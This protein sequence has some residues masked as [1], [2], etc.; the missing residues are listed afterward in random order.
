MSSLA[1]GFQVATLITKFPRL[2]NYKVVLL[3]FDIHYV[4][5]SELGEKH[6]I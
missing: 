4:Q 2:I 1:F 3:I 5:F 6:F